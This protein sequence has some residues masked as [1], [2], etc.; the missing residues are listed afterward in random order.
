MANDKFDRGKNSKIYFRMTHI[1]SDRLFAN[2]S[3]YSALDFIDTHLLGTYLLIIFL[4]R[5]IIN[6]SV[7][8]FVVS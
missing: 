5:Q 1:T 6:S 4:I 8:Q 2:R 3:F 7:R